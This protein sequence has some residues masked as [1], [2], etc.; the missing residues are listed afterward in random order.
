MSGKRKHNKY[1][2]RKVHRDGITFG[3][4]AESD[5]YAEL[6]ALEKACIIRDL[7]PHPVYRVAWPGTKTQVCR[8]TADAE[9]VRDDRLVVEDTKGSRGT[10]KTY[11]RLRAKL[12]ALA[13]NIHV[14]F[15]D[16][17]GRLLWETGKDNGIANH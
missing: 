2:A 7:R 9:Y 1:G 17:K 13:H 12:A 10:I 11:D 3:S 4:R 14:Q 8:Y 16:K 5:R 6:Q 15:V